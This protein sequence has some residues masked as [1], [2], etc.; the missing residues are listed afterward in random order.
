MSIFSARRI[1][2]RFSSMIVNCLLSLVLISMVGIVNVYGG[3]MNV[4]KNLPGPKE[5]IKKHDD[6]IGTK[7]LYNDSES[8]MGIMQRDNDGEWSEL[9]GYPEDLP[10]SNTHVDYYYDK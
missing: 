9:E 7:V 2:I 6:G 3:P 8:E 5:I 10:S 4:R 1:K